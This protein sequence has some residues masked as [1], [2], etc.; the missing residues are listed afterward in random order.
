MSEQATELL[1]WGW[2]VHLLVDWLLQNEWQAINKTSLRHPAAYVHS[3]LHG[4][5]Q[6]LVFAWP[7]ALVIG[8]THLLI[9]TR[10]PVIWWQR[11]IRQTQPNPAT[12]PTVA[13]DIGW[14]I[15]IWVDQVFHLAVVALVALV[16]AS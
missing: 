6:L 12:N 10:K 11:L 4:L 9:D 2:V 8:V 16:A 13:F 1:V 14:D 3:G 5:A 15:R 7:F